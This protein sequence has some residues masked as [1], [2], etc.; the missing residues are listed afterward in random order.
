MIVRMS[1][2]TDTELGR[3]DMA[4]FE[5]DASDNNQAIREIDAEAA[6]HGCAYPGV[7]ASN[8]LP[9]RWPRRTPGFLLP[10]RA[11]AAARS[12]RGA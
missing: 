4:W 2:H 6:E 7:L 12:S 3:T 11:F 8:L 10:P 9:P 5:S 1:P